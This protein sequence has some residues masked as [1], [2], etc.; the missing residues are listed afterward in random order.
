MQEFG[1]DQI[2]TTFQDQV[3]EMNAELSGS[4]SY[5]RLSDHSIMSAAGLVTCAYPNSST[6][7]L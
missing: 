4:C 6:N 1:P 2:T 3:V 5:Q 7:Q